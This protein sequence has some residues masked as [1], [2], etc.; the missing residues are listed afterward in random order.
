MS[1]TVG[2]HCHTCGN[3]INHANSSLPGGLGPLFAELGCPVR[4]WD[5]KTGVELLP[6]LQSAVSE[7]TLDRDIGDYRRRHDTDP[8]GWSRVDFA[9]TFLT[10]LRDAF[11]SEP[12]ATLSV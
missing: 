4:E 2:V 11:C 7:L 12:Y 5:G 8:T 10:A 3:M 9:L 1:S 6:R